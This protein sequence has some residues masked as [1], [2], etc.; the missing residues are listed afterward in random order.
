MLPGVF[1]S[2][3]YSGRPFIAKHP[4]VNSLLISV[5]LEHQPSS[6]GVIGSRHV[7]SPPCL[8]GGH[9]L[10]F[11]ERWA[12]QKRQRSGLNPA[13]QP[14]RPRQ[15]LE[16]H[17]GQAQNYRLPHGRGCSNRMV[18]RSKREVADPSDK[19]L[20]NCFPSPQEAAIRNETRRITLWE[21]RR[22][23]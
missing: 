1:R 18:W 22:N 14:T 19:S 15:N 3:L 10:K 12:K 4:A 17:F 9:F 21:E 11:E 6:A 7:S 16:Q 13:A 5:N 2:R 20:L 8:W 23:F